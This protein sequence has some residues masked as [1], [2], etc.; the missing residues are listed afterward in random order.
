MK[1]KADKE[2]PLTIQ[3]MQGIVTAAVSDAKQ[4]QQ[5]T[6]SLPKVDQEGDSECPFAEELYAKHEELRKKVQQRIAELHECLGVVAEQIRKYGNDL[7]VVSTHE[8]ELNRDRPRAHFSEAEAQLAA[9][10]KRYLQ[11]QNRIEQ[12]ILFINDVLEQA[13]AKRFPG[14]IPQ[15]R[16]QLGGASGALAAQTD[17]NPVG[18]GKS[19]ADRELTALFEMKLNPE[20]EN[21]DGI[22]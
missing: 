14:K 15:E 16:P 4:L 20:D 13:S 12:A 21:C 6:G 8:D 2:Q 5:S 19:G 1:T 10:Y 18:D 17:S 22:H 7:V 9:V 3:E 11:L